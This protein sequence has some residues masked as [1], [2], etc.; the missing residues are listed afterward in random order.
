MERGRRFATPNRQNWGGA[1]QFKRKKKA[2]EKKEKK[3][4]IET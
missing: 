3:W 1:F 4:K 2:Y